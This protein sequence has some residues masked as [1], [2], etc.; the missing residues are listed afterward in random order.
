[1][2][3]KNNNI[4][5]WKK[6]CQQSIQWC[7]GPNNNCVETFFLSTIMSNGRRH[8]YTLLSAGRLY[9]IVFVSFLFAYSDDATMMV[10]SRAFAFVEGS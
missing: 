6:Q 4:Q 2:H 5:T 1:M 3:G 10:C 7:I 9:S 8:I